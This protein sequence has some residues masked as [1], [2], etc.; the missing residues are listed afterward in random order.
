MAVAPKT[1]SLCFNN[2]PSSSSSSSSSVLLKHKPHFAPSPKRFV[3]HFT[4]PRFLCLVHVPPSSSP[5]PPPSSSYALRKFRP[6]RALAVQ[7]SVEQQNDDVLSDEEQSEKLGRPCEVYVCN[8]PRTY[9]TE[10]L[11]DMFN[12]HGTVLS[13]KVCRNAETGESRGCGYVTMASINSARNAILAL[14]GSDVGEREVR[15]RFSVEMNRGRRDPENLNSSAKIVLYYESPH[16]LYV[17][18]L[19][20]AVRPEMLRSIFS[21]FGNVVSARVLHDRKHGKNRVYAFLSF[22]SEAERNAALSLN[23][24]ELYDRTLIVREGVER[25]EP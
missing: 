4:H 5:P 2:T 6:C 15:V 23:G 17:G 8:L 12:P 16:K 9:D 18:N 3:S 13:V 25:T 1:L 10:H 24:M 19:A 7:E 20:R 11:L 14:D 22:Q 21:R